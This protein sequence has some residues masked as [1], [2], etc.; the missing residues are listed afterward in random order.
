[1]RC[2]GSGAMDE[3][4]PPRATN[5]VDLIDS[6]VEPPL[7][8]PIP[9]TPET[10]GWWVLGA[11]LLTVLAYG[12]W[13][14]WLD[15]RA[16]AYRRAALKALDAAGDEPAAVAAVLRRAALAAYPRVDVAS[17][18]GEAWVGFLQEKGTFPDAAGP[19]LIHAPYAA[20]P[21]ADASRVL[22]NA[23]KRWIQTH[24]PPK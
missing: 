17:R 19:A 6:L 12:A 11:L 23:A 22:R 21:R 5:L 15:W 3:E 14:F 9:L 1:M 7:P 10:A 20:A 13:R 8:E 18:T 2:A 4:A 16:N 24:R